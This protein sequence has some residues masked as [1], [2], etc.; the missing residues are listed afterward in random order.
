MRAEHRSLELLLLTWTAGMLDALAYMR[1]RAFTANMTGNTVL[2]G[3]ALG[4]SR[5]E[6]VLPCACALAGFI[7][8]AALAAL[9][10]IR[11][12]R[13]SSWDRDLKI[14]IMMELP[15]LAAF[16]LLRSRD[17]TA[18]WSG[19]TAALILCG[20]CALGIQSVAVRR[21]R[22]RGVVT[23]FITGTVTATITRF[24]SSGESA[25][26]EHSAGP[27]WM[28]TA[29]LVTYTVA[30]AAAATLDQ[31][32]PSVASFIPVATAVAVEIRVLLR[33]EAEDVSRQ[34]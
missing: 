29:M 8:G 30:A 11:L 28:L 33:R 24:V 34:P 19:A 7:A 16:A 12:V 26:P 13:P 2:L 15:F 10:I 14:G 17:L 4:G 9:V 21:L 31:W 18:G 22:I 32:H 27:K 5:S 23:T 6:R 20:A 25:E 3:L 1:A